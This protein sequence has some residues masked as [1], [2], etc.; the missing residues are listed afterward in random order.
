MRTI[1]I[2]ILALVAPAVARGWLFDLFGGAQVVAHKPPKEITRFHRYLDE[3]SVTLEEIEKRIKTEKS[4]KELTDVFAGAMVKLSGME[5]EGRKLYI[6]AVLN[7]IFGKANDY[8]SFSSFCRSLKD[9]I[10]TMSAKIRYSTIAEMEREWKKSSRWM[11]SHAIDAKDPPIKYLAVTLYM[12]YIRLIG[13]ACMTGTSLP[14]SDAQFVD[15]VRS[16]QAFI[17]QPSTSFAEELVSPYKRVHSLLFDQMP[18]SVLDVVSA[19]TYIMATTAMLLPFTTELALTSSTLRKVNDHI[20]LDDRPPTQPDGRIRDLRHRVVVYLGLHYGYGNFLK[21]IRERVPFAEQ[22]SFLRRFLLLVV[23]VI[24]VMSK[25]RQMYY[26]QKSLAT[27]VPE[28]ENMCDAHNV[29]SGRVLDTIRLLAGVHRFEKLETYMQNPENAKLTYHIIAMQNSVKTYTA[30][31]D[32]CR[33]QSSPG[34][35]LQS[36]TLLI[37]HVIGYGND[38]TAEKILDT[39]PE[40]LTSFVGG[41]NYSPY[42]LKYLSANGLAV[43]PQWYRET[44]ERLTMESKGFISPYNHTVRCTLQPNELMTVRNVQKPS[45]D[46]WPP[47]VTDESLMTAC[48]VTSRKEKLDMIYKCIRKAPNSRGKNVFIQ[49]LSEQRRRGTLEQLRDFIMYIF[50]M[51]I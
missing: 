2:A 8:I 48:P 17:Q 34:A 32:A 25:H 28:L 18:E 9:D 51:I 50:K 12:T 20:A 23:D 5:K 13:L 31:A 1:P 47:C 4:R 42:L 43:G 19:K 6:S 29:K 37:P 11:Q 21:R 14:I 7:I 39:F 41:I 35:V 49:I 27:A 33:A 40:L 44:M 36:Q 22:E 10:I 24:Q 16:H 45:P 30:F 38:H 26:Q 46:N 15:F 3:W